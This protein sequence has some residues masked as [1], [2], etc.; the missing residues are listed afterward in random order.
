[1]G[2]FIGIALHYI[3]PENTKY[4]EGFF[5]VS[6]SIYFKLLK[7]SIFPLVFFSITA[8]MLQISKKSNIG[9]LFFSIVF[10]LAVTVMI[11]SLVSVFVAKAFHFSP[12]SFASLKSTTPLN[13][14]FQNTSLF[15]I[16]LNIIPSNPFASLAG[17]GQNAMLSVVFFAFVI[18]IATLTLRDTMPQTFSTLIGF[19]VSFE[20]VMMVI[21]KSII[22]LVPYFV[23][24]IIA[25]L[26]FTSSFQSLEIFISFFLAIYIAIAIMFIIHLLLISLMGFSPLTFLKKGLDGLLFAFSTSNSAGTLAISKETLQNKFGI[27]QEI[28]SIAPTLAISIG[29]NACGG[30]YPSM[31]AIITALFV[32][33][34]PFTIGFISK[35]VI[36][37]AISSLGIVGTGGGTLASIVLLPLMNLPLTLVPL[38]LAVEPLLDM[39]RTFL[40]VSGGWVSALF[41]ARIN[42]QVNMDIYNQP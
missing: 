27:D 10:P 30:I 19:F 41:S 25:K 24:P 42:K 15:D 7:M 2:L 21:I 22:R 3:S 11:S 37:C 28:A 5:N 4:V 32:G 39:A 23:M 1:M 12:D 18:S 34:D 17:I 9:K 31:V 29:Q 33:V 14:P 16:F 26:V 20:R 40:N 35:M 36:L 13:N 6:S 8:A 38:F